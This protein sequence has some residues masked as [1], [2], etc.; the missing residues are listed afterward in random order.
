MNAAL[1]AD[2]WMQ[3]GEGAR[4]ALDC[5]CHVGIARAALPVVQGWSSSACHLINGV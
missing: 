4:A 2:R 3:G 5:H 1:M